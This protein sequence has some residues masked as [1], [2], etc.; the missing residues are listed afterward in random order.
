MNRRIL[1]TGGAG[2]VGSHSC[3]AFNQ[4][5]WDVVVVDNLVRG[6]SDA[7]RW[8]KL[9]EGDIGDE[10]AMRAIL[11]Q[12]RP[13]VVAHFAAYAYV[14]E[15]VIDPDLY[16]RNNVA[17]T[18]ALL[19]AM[20]AEDVTSLVFSSSCATYG[21]PDRLPITEDMR[22]QPINPYGW[23]KLMVE[24]MLK[25]QAVAYALNSISLRYF[26]A[27]GCD[28]EGEIGER[29]EP[30]THAI[31][32][33][34]AAALDGTAF[35]INGSDFATRDG[36]A[37]RDYIHVSDLADAH[38]AAAE[39][40]YAGDH[41]AEFFNL[42]TGRGVTVAELAD[43]VEDAAGLPLLR[44]VGPRRPGDPAE[45]VAA[46]GLAQTVLGWSARQSDLANIVH[47]ALAW[48]RKRRAAL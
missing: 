5:G 33:A 21:V 4:A 35:T 39:R 16:Y 29:H 47:T 45:L 14:G 23:S 34:L 27:A 15:S 41:G 8:G 32:L 13:D 3:K 48:E 44:Q 38:V 37:M 43:A 9:I 12:E 28:A 30:E 22:Q 19:A 11:A 1:V 17:G 25:D 7:V 42:G 24:Q 6:W 46:P 40:L 20:R 36:T 2:Y 26:N 10:S 31:P 18:R